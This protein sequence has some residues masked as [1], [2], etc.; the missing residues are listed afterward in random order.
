MK[1]RG[2]RIKALV[3]LAGVTIDE[4]EEALSFTKAEYKVVM[5]R[6]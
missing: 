5:K 1:N 4:Y 3:E 6:D 2:R